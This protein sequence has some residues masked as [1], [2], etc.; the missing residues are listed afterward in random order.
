MQGRSHSSHSLNDGHATC[1]TYCSK[2]LSLEKSQRYGNPAG[3]VIPIRLRAS[4]RRMCTKSR[5]YDLFLTV[6][7]RKAAFKARVHG[8][9]ASAHVGMCAC[10]MHQYT[11]A[12]RTTCDTVVKTVK[13]GASCR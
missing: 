5:L 7:T 11:R 13:T 3:F 12:L 4:E 10:I 6:G 2:P 8:M 9:R 1:G